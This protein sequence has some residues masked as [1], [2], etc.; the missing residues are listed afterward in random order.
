MTPWKPDEHTVL[1]SE[2]P[3]TRSELNGRS[4]DD[5]I[6]DLL[7]TLTDASIAEECE[8]GG[9]VLYR[10]LLDSE[11]HVVTAQS[12]LILQTV[13]DNPSVRTAAFRLVCFQLKKFTA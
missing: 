7:C 1:T 6:S 2:T 9:A 4:A 3:P 13:A 5:C 10:G 8:D 12:P 11:V